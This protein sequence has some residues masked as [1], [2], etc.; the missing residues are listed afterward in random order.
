MVLRNDLRKPSL[1]A[2]GHVTKVLL[3]ENHGRWQGQAG[4]S[5]PP[6]DFHTVSV[7]PPKFQKFFHF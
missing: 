6:L 7:N 4:G 2:R 5:W 3:A 1:E